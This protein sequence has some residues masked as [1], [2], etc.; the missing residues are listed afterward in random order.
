[1]GAEA[2]RNN[3]NDPMTAGLAGL[4]IG[5]AGGTAAPNFKN[6]LL[7]NWKLAQTGNEA[8]TEL[9]LNKLQAQTAESIAKTRPKPI[10]A[11]LFQG[12]DGLQ[13]EYDPATKT[14]HAIPGQGRRSG[15]AKVLRTVERAGKVWYE[16]EEGLQPALD[17]STGV[18]LE[19][20]SGESFVDVPGYGRVRAGAAYTADRAAGD[21]SHADVVEAQKVDYENSIKRYE[22]ADKAVGELRKIIR[23]AQ[24]AAVAANN[25]PADATEQDK[26]LIWQTYEDKKRE[27]QRFGRDIKARYP[28]LVEDDDMAY[29]T[30][31][32]PRPSRSAP[33][34]RG[35]AA[36]SG[37][38]TIEGAIQ[39]FKDKVKRAPNAE[40]IEK[41][42]VA[43]GQ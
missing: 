2:A 11:K 32:K 41:M 24:E 3:P 18:Q 43:L 28:D 15:S 33:P 16:T 29:P 6:R 27:A 22:E 23:D 37:G 36:R 39:A 42:R 31:M 30:R 25:P 7:R 5:L 14:A 17:P 21:K 19:A 26:R 4:A 20:E 35:R 8:K 13:Y 38:R 10:A 12:A 9:E 40:E 1:M 34:V